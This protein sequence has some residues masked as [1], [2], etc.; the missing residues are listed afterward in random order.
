MAKWGWDHALERGLLDGYLMGKREEGDHYTQ[1]AVSEKEREE[2]GPK[3]N[4]A[5]GVEGYPPILAKQDP[6][7]CEP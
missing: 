3:G 4:P 5:V 2:P 1:D 7:H 6:H